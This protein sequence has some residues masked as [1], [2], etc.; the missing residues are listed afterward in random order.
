MEL[1]I[2]FGHKVLYL[3]LRTEIPNGGIPRQAVGCAGKVFEECSGCSLWVTSQSSDKIHEC[4]SPEQ[5][6]R[7]RIFQ[8]ESTTRGVT[9]REGA[10]GFDPET[11]TPESA[12]NLALSGRTIVISTDPRDGLCAE[13]SRIIV[14]TPEEWIDIHAKVSSLHEFFDFL[15]VLGVT[16]TNREFLDL[17]WKSCADPETL[18]EAVAMLQNPSGVDSDS[19]VEVADRLNGSKNI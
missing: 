14:L 2:L 12:K 13:P 3:A 11:A 8:E 5:G 17:L 15:R 18:N 4:L 9:T 19:F 1:H 7:F 10:A 16:T 6:L